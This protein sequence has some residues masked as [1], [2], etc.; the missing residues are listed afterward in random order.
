MAEEA[1]LEPILK[2]EDDETFSDTDVEPATAF[3]HE[4]RAALDVH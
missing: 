1:A 3:D 2:D 4:E